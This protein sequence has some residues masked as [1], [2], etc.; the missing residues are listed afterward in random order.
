MKG[1]TKTLFPGQYLQGAGVISRLP[2]LINKRGQLALAIISPPV[3]DKV[4][5]LIQG[6]AEC[7]FSTDRC[8]LAEIE[9]LKSLATDVGATVIVGCGGGNT[10]DLSK[11]IADELKLANIVCPTTAASDAPCSSVSMVNDE[12]CIRDRLY[13]AP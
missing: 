9:R 4:T 11:A 3:Y 10:I 5:P 12:M 7:V 2:S 1:Y 6:S 13:A 8:T